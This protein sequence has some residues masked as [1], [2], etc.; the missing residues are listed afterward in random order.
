[1]ALESSPQTVMVPVAQLAEMRASQAK[2]EEMLAAR[3]LETT[4]ATLRAA[5]VSGQFEQLASSHR[6]ELQAE[7]NRAAQIAAR[8]ELTSELSKQQ[9]VPHAAEQ[10]ASILGS[11]L[12]TSPDGQGNY[13]VMSRDYR[14]VG[15]YIQA[16]LADPAYAHFR[17]DQKPAAPVNRPNQPAPDTSIEQPRN[18]GEALIANFQSQRQAAEAANS[19]T[20]PRMDLSKPMGLGPARGG[21]AWGSAFPGMGRTR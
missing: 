4:T 9:L 8:A 16:K 21:P 1:M 11:E 6:Q 15:E 20:D 18:F 3:E 2:M 12:I 7:R 10:L 5:S 17:A 14:P 13:R 19:A